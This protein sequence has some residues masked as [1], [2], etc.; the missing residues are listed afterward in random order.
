MKYAGDKWV[1]MRFTVSRKT[2]K[3][4]S[5]YAWKLT[6]IKFFS[7]KK[8]NRIFLNDHNGN[9]LTVSRKLTRIFTT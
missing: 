6:D 3:N 2:A 4:F 8:I 9:I 5:C 7:R 1:P